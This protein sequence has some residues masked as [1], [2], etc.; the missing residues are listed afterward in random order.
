[1]TEVKVVKGIVHTKTKVREA[2]TYTVVNRNDA[3][4]TVLIEHPVRKEFTLS[5]DDKPLETADDV[6]RFQLKVAPGKTETKTVSEEQDVK[7]T[8]ELTNSSDEQMR[9]FMSQ[10]AT[11]DKVKAGLK[12]AMEL[13]WA[14]AKTQREIG[15]LQRQLDAIVQ[16]QVR[17][18]ANL[19]EMPSTAAAY[20]R[21]LE[22]FDKQEEEIEKYQADIKR[23]QGTEHQQ[24]KEFDD[25]LNNFSAD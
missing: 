15:E 4:R 6:Y 22:K 25:F 21:Y 10:T 17:L 3:E 20:K 23:L 13:R 14:L 5:G 16:D 18:R 9:W 11:S 7:E 12:Q 2:R 24:K 8:V 1:V 19:K